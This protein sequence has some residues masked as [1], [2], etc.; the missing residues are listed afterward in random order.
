MYSQPFIPMVTFEPPKSIEFF[1][2]GVNRPCYRTLKIQNK[3]DTS[4]IFEFSD[5]HNDFSI[6]PKTGFIKGIINS[7]I[8]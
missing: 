5:T 1:S 7:K 6:I 4:T 8:F 2:K 3:T